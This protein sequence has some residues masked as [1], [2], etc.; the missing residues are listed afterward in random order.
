MFSNAA[1]FG[2]LIFLPIVRR[3]EDFP[4]KGNNIVVGLARS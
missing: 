1:F 4:V 3:T 2:L